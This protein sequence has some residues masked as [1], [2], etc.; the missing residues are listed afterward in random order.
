MSG[1]AQKLKQYS[2]ELK[3]S[4]SSI[5]KQRLITKFNNYF[6]QKQVS[7]PRVV[8][9]LIKKGLVNSSSEAIDYL[10]NVG[11]NPLEDVVKSNQELN[12]KREEIIKKSAI[13][14][15]QNK[16]NDLL[17]KQTIKANKQVEDKITELKRL[18]EKATKKLIGNVTK[19][20]KEINKLKSSQGK[21]TKEQ[22][23]FKLKKLRE[24][25]LKA[26]REVNKI[27]NSGVKQLSRDIEK[28]KEENTKNAKKLKKHIKDLEKQKSYVKRYGKFTSKY[29]NDTNNLEELKIESKV[30]EDSIK[31]FTAWRID[32]NINASSLQALYDIIIKTIDNL[33]GNNAVLYFSTTNNKIRHITID[34][35]YLSDYD[36]F[37]DRIDSI[38]SG[39]VTGSD[40]LDATDDVDY[41]LLMDTFNIISNKLAGGAGDCE[42]MIFN[43]INTI[44][45]PEHNGKCGYRCIAYIIGFNKLG[46]DH[47]IEDFI[48]EGTKILK[49]KY[50][51]TD[52]LAFNTFSKLNTFLWNNKIYIGLY[53]NGIQMLNNTRKTV[54]KEGKKKINIAN[55][56]YIINNVVLGVD[57]KEVCFNTEHLKPN[58]DRNLKNIIGNIVFDAKNGHFE[59][60][61]G[62]LEIKKN[63]YV[64]LCSRILKE[65]DNKY[66]VLMNTNTNNFNVDMVKNVETVY[67]AYDIEAVINYKSFSRMSPY[68]I[69]FTEANNEMILKLNEYDED[70]DLKKIKEFKK[71]H[72]TTYNGYDC[73][74][75]FVKWIKENQHEKRFVFIG[76]NSANFDNYMFMDE[77]LNCEYDNMNITNVLYNGSQL[78][79]FTLN[80][81]H[82]CFD[83]NRHLLGSLKSC[84]ES[85]KV[86]SCAKLILDHNEKQ[87]Q[88]DNDP[89]KF[90][91]DIKNDL[92]LKK[93]NENDVL[94]VLCIFVRYRK[95][96]SLIDGM[97]DI[98]KNLEENLTIGGMT[99][100][101]L[102]S[103]WSEK[104]IKLPKLTYEQYTDLQKSK[105]A[106][107]VEMFNGKLFLADKMVSYDV[108][109]LYPYVM[110]ISDVYYPCGEIVETDEYVADKIGF[111]Y[112]DVDQSNLI[113]NNLPL[114]YAEKTETC[115]DWS[116]ENILYN[117]LLSSAII[118]LLLK[119]D[120]KVNIR[121]G[122]YF[123]DK[124]KS[125]EM[126]EPILKMMKTKNDQDILSKNNDVTYNP[127]LREGTKLMMN[128]GSGKVIEGVHI[129]KIDMVNCVEDY[130][131]LTK[132]KT[133]INV[134][135]TV[136]KNI[137]V[138]YK[139]DEIETTEKDQRPIYLG[140]LI[141]DYAKI[142]MYENFYSVVGKDK[143][144]YTD[145][146]AGKIREKDNT[147][148]L[149]HAL[150]TA[151]PHWVEVEKYDSR[152]ST[153]KMFNTN[154]KVFGSFEDELEK[155]NKK[156]DDCIFSCI[157]K[158]SWLYKCGDDVKFKFKGVNPNSII[159][160]GD[161][162]FLTSELIKNELKYIC[163]DSKKQETNEYFNSSKNSVKNNA[164]DFF[165]KICEGQ[166]VYVLCQQF[167]KNVRN[168]KRNVMIDEKQKYNTNA[169]SVSIIYLIKKIK[170]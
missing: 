114:I 92:D 109:S 24:K 145:T 157:Q 108:C 99:Y 111:Y 167:K 103:N 26:E 76:F 59:V 150:N 156:S 41:D 132:D 118:E 25:Q 154:S 28:I 158:K 151:V 47:E 168:T 102:N 126:F 91:E 60:V 23:S 133:D 90:M 7:L 53:A 113:K 149:N 68:S 14:K 72:T 57:C 116:S 62:D 84:C 45:E 17:E 42:N 83:L 143:L 101:V 166:T 36:D 1:D 27:N 58:E 124:R 148:W 21:F 105:I 70:N 77:I 98:A 79:N 32:L 40:A 152:Y 112:C 144:I 117:Y 9:S 100:K 64:S 11:I 69:S 106:G 34:G 138:S 97:G 129:S 146:D 122:F 8:V 38:L 131:K 160:N 147:K 170:I 78:L 93:Y 163:D 75:K 15:E 110:C 19:L 30:A 66:S 16:Y 120:C 71:E 63:I 136:G 137:I 54:M 3:K 134:I 2:N 119:F 74:A 85:F 89:I 55:R 29:E 121:N 13:K 81:R 86:K 87:K 56:Q 142:Y 139:K 135:N 35:N 6:K 141:Y 95:A 73:M 96:L 12:K 4:V 43:T 51:I 165:K 44:Y 80:G 159:L 161:E 50:K 130:V 104:K 153:H 5:E 65:V 22:K 155:M 10:N 33:N 49:N 164:V 37:V 115:N 48:D 20:D 94:S 52:E 128:A 61:I 31:H 107:R 67:I 46:D 125:C 140:V 88:F 18:N 169:N 39:Q 123:T 82:T 162:E 127:A